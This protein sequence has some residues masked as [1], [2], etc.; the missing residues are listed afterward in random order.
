[1]KNNILSREQFIKAIDSIKKAIE[2]EEKLNNLI[3]EY[4]IDGFVFFNEDENE[5]LI[6]TLE[7]MFECEVDDYTGT[8]ISYFCYELDFGK[9]WKPGV[10]TCNG[11][12]INLSDAGHLYDYL[13]SQLEDNKKR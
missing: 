12:D 2:I 3:K 11:E 4:C 8:D 9:E 10:I 1:M 7:V 13:I 6:N 5:Q